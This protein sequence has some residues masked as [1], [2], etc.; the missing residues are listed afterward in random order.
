VSVWTAAYDHDMVDVI[1]LYEE[2]ATAIARET[3]VALRIAPNASRG[4]LRSP[5]AYDAYLRGMYFWLFSMS[6]NV[7]A[8]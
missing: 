4:R 2:I 3:S 6:D 5:D 7:T 1:T 8:T